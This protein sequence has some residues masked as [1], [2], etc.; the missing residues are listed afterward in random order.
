LPSHPEWKYDK[1]GWTNWYDFLDI[2]KKDYYS[3]YSE[4]K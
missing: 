1:N 4:A 2:E 3:T